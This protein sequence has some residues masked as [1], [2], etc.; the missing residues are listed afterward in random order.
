MVWFRLAQAHRELG[1]TAQAIRAG[2]RFI[3]LG[4]FRP[5]RY[6]YQLAQAYAST[7]NNDKALDWL[8][9]AL[10]ARRQNRA[11][12]LDDEAFVALRSDTRF[13]ELVGVPPS[14]GNRDNGW[15]LDLD[16]LVQ[17]VQRLHAGYDRPA[18]S[19]EFL[20]AAAQLRER[21]PELT[22]DQIVVG[23]TRLVGMLGDG[24]SSVWPF[25]GK[26]PFNL[27][28]LPLQ[29][30]SFA[31]G[32]YIVDG[33]GPAAELVGAEVLSMGP[34]DPIKALAEIAPY[35]GHDNAM[36]GNW[37]GPFV[38]Q[39]LLFLQAI[40]ASPDGEHVTLRV[41]DRS[42]TT[43]EVTLGGVATGMPTR[44]GLP[45]GA[46]ARTPV[47]LENI[48][49][50]YWFR[51]LPEHDA[52]YFQFNSVRNS[53]GESIA[54]FAGRLK[55][56]LRMI[57]P[58]NLIVDVRHN[59]GGNN[60]LMTPLLRTLVAFQEADAKNRIFV[61]TGR[62]TF[63]AAQNFINF[64]ER[65]TDAIFVGEPSSSKP[66]F[67]GETAMFVLPYSGI[68]GSISNRYWQDGSPGDDREM[69]Y[70]EVPVP[71]TAEDYFANRD[72]A[73]EAIFE[74]VRRS[75]SIP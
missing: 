41:R 42:G 67:V 3:Q 38:L 62:S 61:I 8:D 9:A 47:Y 13:A 4:F 33:T 39:R 23:L 5:D 58:A 17:D 71:P 59:N 35:W 16:Y 21:I 36:M 64:V 43:R 20:R 46:G 2:E 40:G 19:D 63:S 75:I 45:P 65:L 73:L 10:Q 60:T 53:E 54:D 1:E 14:A 50:N 44:I 32:M 30:Y 66:N 12:I 52:V 51:A 69:I 70:P 27:N 72:A 48:G 68:R 49:T 25:P 7:G 29:L 34:L 55:D 26:V 31:D 37:I 24:H 18:H 15:R 57:E 74:I 6:G 22:N 11:A 28:A 56:S